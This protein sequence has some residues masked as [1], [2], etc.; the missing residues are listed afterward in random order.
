MTV[1]DLRAKLKN[2]PSKAIIV[3]RGYEEGVNEAD[4]IAEC[5]IKPF[6]QGKQWYYGTFE[7]SQGDGEKAIF[8]SSARDREKGIS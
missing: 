2:M 3:V 1:A 6:S 5:N 8:I 4:C 7:L